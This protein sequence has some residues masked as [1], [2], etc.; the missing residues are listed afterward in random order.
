[1]CLAG[2]FSLRPAVVCLVRFCGTLALF[3]QAFDQGFIRSD[4]P[5]YVTNNPRVQ[6]GLHGAGVRADGLPTI[7]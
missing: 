1:M 4:D 2:S 5:L 3:S 7:R 6:G